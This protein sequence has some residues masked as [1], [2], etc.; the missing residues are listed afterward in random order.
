MYPSYPLFSSPTAN[1]WVQA[2]TLSPILPNSILLP[3]SSAKTLWMHHLYGSLKHLG[4]CKSRLSL[5]SFTWHISLSKSSWSFLATLCPAVYPPPTT[6]RWVFP[7]HPT[8]SSLYAFAFLGLECHHFSQSLL[9]PGFLFICKSQLR[10]NLLE[11]F[12]DALRLDDIRLFLVAFTVLYCVLPSLSSPHSIF[13]VIS[14][15]FSFVRTPWG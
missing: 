7:A 8:V 3:L 2:L 10:S 15:S 1:A 9:I 5:D 12:P 13:T 4:R 6:N 14:L 11:I